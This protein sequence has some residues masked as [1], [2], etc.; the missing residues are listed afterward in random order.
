MIL[1]DATLGIL[2]GGQLGRMFT[3]AAYSMGYRVVVLD[4]DPHSPAGMIADQHIKAD[5]RDHAALQMLGDEC[6]AVT[7]EFENIPADSLDYLQQ[8]CTVRPGPD[9]VRIAQDR[10]REKTF[11]RDHGLSTAAFEPVYE[12]ADLDEAFGELQPPMLLKTASLGYDGKGQVRVDTLEDAR[13]AFEQLGNRPCVLEEMVDLAREISVVLARGSNGR[14]AVYPVAE[15]LHVNGILDTT[16]VPA[17]IDAQSRDNAVLMAGQLAGAMDYCGV[18]AVEFFITRQGELLV[19]ELATRPH[20]SGHFTVDACATSQFEQ[21][22]RMLCDLPPGDTQLL[23]P[24]VMLNLLGD[25]WCDDAAPDWPAVFSE[26]GAHLHLYGKR[27]ARPGRK[28]GHINSLAASVEDARAISEDL[29]RR[30]TAQ[31]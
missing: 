17:S 2:G 3:L 19:N 22:L 30:L 1:P 24:V 26:P 7:T 9:A 6:A 15:N 28:M 10:I 27:E 29:R 23:S 4:P 14:L 8:F 5:Y 12:A 16:V 25:L 31:R 20:N 18:L 11:I 13:S 21:Q